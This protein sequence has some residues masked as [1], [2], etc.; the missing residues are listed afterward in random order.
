L[1]LGVKLSEIDNNKHV[2]IV[3]LPGDI[4]IIPQATLGAQLK[5]KSYQYHGNIEKEKG[6]ILFNKFIELLEKNCK[7]NT[8]WLEAGKTIQNGTYGNRQ[9]YSTET[10]GPYLHLIEF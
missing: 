6:F 9:I 8:K 1:I 7:E 5:G 4:L 10:N 3:D 2:S